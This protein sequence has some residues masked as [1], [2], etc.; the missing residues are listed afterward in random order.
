[1][2]YQQQGRKR[3]DKGK[4]FSLWI[5]EDEYWVLEEIERRVT[6]LEMG[7]FQ[8]SA[9]LVIRAMLRDSIRQDEKKATTGEIDESYRG[10]EGEQGRG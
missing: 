3:P 9:N 7:G 5:P 10:Q 2:S 6:M 8:A 4:R 1:M